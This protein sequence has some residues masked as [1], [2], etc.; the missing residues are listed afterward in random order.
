MEVV[1]LGILKFATIF[2][3]FES[4][5]LSLLAGLLPSC[6]KSLRCVYIKFWNP[7]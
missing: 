7:C 6:M 4:E 2:F 5:M 3:H 1:V